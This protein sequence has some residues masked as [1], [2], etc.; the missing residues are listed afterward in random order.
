MSLDSLTNEERAAIGAALSTLRTVENHFRTRDRANAMLYLTQVRY[1]PITKLVA[2]S[3]SA[4]SRIF[5][6]DS[7]DIESDKEEEQVDHMSEPGEP[8]LDQSLSQLD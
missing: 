3:A 8:V 2:R 4:L 5:D 7:V 1:S 6:A